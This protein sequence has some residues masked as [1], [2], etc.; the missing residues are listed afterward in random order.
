MP[1][2]DYRCPAC[3]A[4]SELYRSISS[5]AKPSCCGSAMVQIHKSAPS[6]FVQAAAHYL[7]PVTLQPV[8]TRHQ[9]SE[10]MKRE[11]LVEARPAYEVV[12]DRKKWRENVTA[13]ANAG[14][15]LA[16]EQIDKLAKQAR[17]Q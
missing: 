9:R 10:I 15:Q 11:N 1:L 7:C 13:L 17:L 16:P 6:G 5:D 4:E 2:Y 14:P 8:T 12:R 3:G